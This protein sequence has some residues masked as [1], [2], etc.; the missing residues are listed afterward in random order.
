MKA[1]PAK[2]FAKK[3]ES[4]AS[5]EEASQDAAP[6]KGESSSSEEQG[7]FTREDKL[8]MQEYKR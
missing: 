8:I 4:S 7:V 2:P 3:D 1:K 6:A 5:D